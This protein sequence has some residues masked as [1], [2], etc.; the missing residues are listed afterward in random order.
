MKKVKCRP[1]SYT[2]LYISTLQKMSHLFYWLG[3]QGISLQP[4][5]STC[6]GKVFLSFVFTDYIGTSTIDLV[7]INVKHAT[8]W[9]NVHV[10]PLKIVI[11]VWKVHQKHMYRVHT[12]HLIFRFRLLLQINRTRNVRWNHSPHDLII[13]NSDSKE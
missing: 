1:Y 13:N 8:L 4:K 6:F 3:W 2:T 10:L 7:I 11:S 5:E 12:H 9:V